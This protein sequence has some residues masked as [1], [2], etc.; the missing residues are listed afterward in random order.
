LVV[1]PLIYRFA[2]KYVISGNIKVTCRGV[3]GDQQKGPFLLQSDLELGP[4]RTLQ[5]VGKS[6]PTSPRDDGIVGEYVEVI[7]HTAF[8]TDGLDCRKDTVAAIAPD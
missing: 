2:S 4:T 8:A 3:R 1:K 5:L 6:L 7:L